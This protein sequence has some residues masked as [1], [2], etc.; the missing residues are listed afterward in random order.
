MIFDCFTFFNELDLLELR[1]RTLWEVVDYFVL[2]EAPFTFRGDAKPLIYAE[3]GERFRPWSSKIVPLVYEAPALDDPW[4]N[5]WGQRDFLIEGLRGARDD[6]LVL[7]GDCDE[8][9]DPVNAARRPSGAGRILGHRQ[10]LSKGWVNRV[11]KRNWVGTRAV[12]LRDLPHYGNLSSV[13]KHPETDL[14]IVDGG[15][16]FTSMGGAEAM[17]AKMRAYAHSE[18]D[19]PYLTD[20]RRLH[21]TFYETDGAL[22]WIPLDDT[23]PSL[24]REP[25]WAAYVASAPSPLDAARAKALE[26]AHG[27]FAYVPSDASAVGVLAWENLD[28]WDRAGRERFGPRYAGAAGSALELLSRLAGGWTVVDGLERL[29]EDDLSA[30]ASASCGIVAYG[31]NARSFQVFDRVL[32]GDAFPAGAALGLPELRT[33]MRRLSGEPERVD[34]VRSQDVFAV[35]SRLPE[36]LYGVILGSNVRFNEIGRDDINDFLTHGVIMVSAPRTAAA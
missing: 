23:F 25:R 14:E 1:L 8:I 15:W 26:H 12:V 22:T 11:H 2:C 5:E 24:F 20:G 18:V 16:H 10:R 21:V 7:L 6:D 13:R 35:W 31:R 19:I 28:A 9:P 17:A 29:T 4:Q 34:R 33:R 32:A 27:C 30:L 3:S 36:K